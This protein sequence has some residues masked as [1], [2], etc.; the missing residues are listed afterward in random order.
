MKSSLAPIP[1]LAALLSIL[2]IQLPPAFSLAFAPPKAQVEISIAKLPDD[3]PAIQDCRRSAYEGKSINL[4]A[5]KSFCNADQIQKEGYICV[6]A[7]DED[8]TVLGTADLSTRT[9]VVNNVYV[10][11]EA[12]KRGIARQMMEAVEDALDRPSTLKLTVMTKNTPAITLYKKMGFEARGMYGG[13]D[14]MS[15]AVGF[16]FLV[17]MT[18]TLE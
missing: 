3:L 18:K 11:T 10:R 6:I 14:A 12:R 7:K 15:S 5:A 8:G 4:P 17:E 1:L 9:K 13:L 16:D 2:V